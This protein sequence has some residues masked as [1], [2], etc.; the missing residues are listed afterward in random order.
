MADIT[1]EVMMNEIPDALIVNWD[2][3]P[4]HIVPTGDWIMHRRGEKVIPLSNL[5]D[6][7]QITA[8]LVVSITGDYL[9]PQ[10]HLSRQNNSLPS[11]S[12]T[13]KRMGHMAF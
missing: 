13:T 1:A 6:K 5:D 3:T 2:Q 7:R 4:L 10:L 8:V 12:N 9:P 11:K